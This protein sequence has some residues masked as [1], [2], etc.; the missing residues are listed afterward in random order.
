M[1]AIADRTCAVIQ[2]LHNYDGWQEAFLF[3]KGD[4]KGN[5]KATTTADPPFDFAQGRLFGD[6]NKKAKTKAGKQK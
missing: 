4:W 3:G 2:R 6:D 5:A 1:G